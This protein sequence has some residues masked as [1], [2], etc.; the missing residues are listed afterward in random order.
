MSAM[1]IIAKNRKAYHDYEVLEK[2]EAGIELKGTEVKSV[3][4]GKINLLD[5]YGICYNGELFIFHMHISPF[6][7]ANRFNHDPYRKRKLLL[8]VREI[9]HL[10]QE[11]ERKKLS[12]IPLSVYFS[13]QRVKVEIGICKGRKKYDKRQKIS[14]EDS[15]RRLQKIVKY[16]K[17]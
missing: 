14:A 5:S 16:S 7:H 9:T 1:K 6:E 3:R 2:Y 13:K 17:K 8:H 15:K 4:G 12:I 10:C 11:V